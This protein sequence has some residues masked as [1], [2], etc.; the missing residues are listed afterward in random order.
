[1]EEVYNHKIQRD[2]QIQDFNKRIPPAKKTKEE[3]SQ[4]TSVSEHQNKSKLIQHDFKVPT[5]PVDSV[6]SVQNAPKPSC[7]HC[8]KYHLGECRAKPE[9]CY[10]CGSTDHFLRNCPK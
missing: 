3:F 5:K 1:M 10:R 6:G 2:R 7:R 9:A 8:G 4:T